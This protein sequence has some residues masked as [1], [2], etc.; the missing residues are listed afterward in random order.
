MKIQAMPEEI[1]AEGVII[2]HLEDATDIGRGC[3]FQVETTRANELLGDY[4]SIS[5]TDRFLFTDESRS[6]TS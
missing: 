5:M 6:A 4:F 1:V 2:P 3:T